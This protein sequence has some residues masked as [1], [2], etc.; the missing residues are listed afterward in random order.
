MKKLVILFTLILFIISCGEKVREDITERYNDGQKKVLVKY[1]GEGSNEEIVNRT[2]YYESGKIEKENN[3]KNGKLDGIEYLYDENGQ[4]SLE[5]K[6]KDGEKWDGRWTIYDDMYKLEGNYKEGKRDGLWN[7]W[8]MNG[9]KFREGTW[10][11][12][13]LISKTE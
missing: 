3:Y 2:F 4:I 11:D 6:Y 10:K 1:K 7:S 12:D 5:R 9:K 13:I 8:Y